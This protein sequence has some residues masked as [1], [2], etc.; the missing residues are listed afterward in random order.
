M[1]MTIIT[2]RKLFAIMPLLTLFGINVAFGQTG[3]ST[4][5]TAVMPTF[6]WRSS[7][8]DSMLNFNNATIVNSGDSL[9]FDSLPYAA[10]YTVVV[11]YRPL[12][13]IEAG[14]WRMGCLVG[15]AAGRRGLT[16]ERIISGNTAIRYDNQTHLK[17]IINTLGQSWPADSRGGHSPGGVPGDGVR[18]VLGKDTLQ[19]RIMV[20]EI[21]YFGS[22]LS[23]RMLRRVQSALAVKYGVTLGPVDYLDGDGNRIWDYCDSGRYHHRI[24]GI[25]RDS[26]YGLHQ[27]CSRSEMDGAVLTVSA[28]SIAEHAFLL[29]GDNGAPLSFAGDGTGMET[30]SRRWRARATNMDGNTFSFVFD[31]RDL[32]S[33]ADSLVLLVG[34]T[35]VPPTAASA[36]SVRFDGVRLPSGTCSFTLAKGSA[37]RMETK[38]KANGQWKTNGADSDRTDSLSDT[39]FSIYPNPTTGHYTIEVSGAKQVQV[40]V[41]NMTGSVVAAYS[42]GGRNRYSFSGDLPSGNSYYATVATESGSQTMKLVVK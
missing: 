18:L 2:M 15:G 9:V 42:D 21:M 5:A 3:Y 32:A 7:T 16:T 40:V 1:L 23:N 28:D 17:P 24:T 12:D 39:R 30:L 35:A 41:Y 37:L 22:R 29:V 26:T 14:V 13:G 8:G 19:G 33:H 34:E 27:P 10:D 20:A 36:G 6:W 4:S 25:G 31:A 38:G 11:V